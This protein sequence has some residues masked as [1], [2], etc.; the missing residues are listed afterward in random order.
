M[1][2][3]YH[4]PEDSDGPKHPDRPADKQIPVTDRCLLGKRIST[5]YY[6][7]WTIFEEHLPFLDLFNHWNR[8][9]FSA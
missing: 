9:N 8:E 2:R 6:Q 5:G 7:V 4:I 3:S 1:D